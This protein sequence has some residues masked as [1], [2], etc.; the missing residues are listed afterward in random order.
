MKKLSNTKA[1]LKKGV[2]YKK[3][4]QNKRPQIA[5]LRITALPVGDARKMKKCCR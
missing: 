2:A 4:S 3:V 5:S 1:E